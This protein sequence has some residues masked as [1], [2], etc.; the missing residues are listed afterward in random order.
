LS[1]DVNAGNIVTN[2]CFTIC[3]QFSPGRYEG[4]INDKD[5]FLENVNAMEMKTT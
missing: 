5:V 4:K 2:G 3:N 1:T